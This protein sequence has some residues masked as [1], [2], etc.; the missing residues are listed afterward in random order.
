MKILLKP[1]GFLLLL[2]CSLNSPAQEYHFYHKDFIGFTLS[3]LPFVDFRFSYE[4]RIT[5]AHGIRMELGYKPAF[6]YITDATQ[7][8]LGQAPTAWC[9][10]NTAEWYYVAMGYRYYFNHNRTAYVSPELFYKRLSADDILYS[11]GLNGGSSTLTNTF[12]LR[13]MKTNMVGLNLLAGKKMRIRLSHGFN[14]GLDVYAG[15]TA[16]LKNI[17][18]VIYGSNTIQH[19]HDSG[20]G[21]FSIPFYPEPDVSDGPVFQVSGQF[22]IVLFAS[23][24]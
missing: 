12:Q 19:Y 8:N 15:L 7:I 6:K 14:M 17:H 13:D 20:V 9:Y 2:S 16:R 4:R 21:T 24:K 5:P 22:G 1:I 3:E 10:R 11:Y 23:W 18:T